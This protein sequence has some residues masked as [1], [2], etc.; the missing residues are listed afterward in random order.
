MP[1]LARIEA[2]E[3]AA[4]LTVSNYTIVLDLP[5]TGAEFQS[6]STIRFS[7]AEP[8]ATTFV[9]LHAVALEAAV[10]NGG[11]VDPAGF[12]DGRLAL[13]GLH[14]DNELRL[15]ARMAYSC[16]GE[17]LHRHVDPTDGRTYLYAMSFLDAAPRWFGC[18][19]QPDLKANFDIE[20]RCPA[21]WTVWGNAPSARLAEGHWRLATT[22]PLSTYFVTLVAG[23]YHSVLAE[24]DGIRLGLHARACLA[25][26]LEA[27]AEEILA[28][29]RAAFDRYHELFGIR[30]P[31]GEYHQAF[32][33]DFNAGAMENPGCVTLREQ[34]IFRSAVTS[35]ERSLR[36][37]VIA[38]EMA[39]MW[40]G[41]LVTM[42]WW[43]DLWLNESFAEYLAYRVCAELAGRTGA[44]ELT[45]LTGLAWAEFGISRKDFGYV[46]DQSPATHPVAGNGAADAATALAAFDGIS[47]A[48]G[49]SALR[50][51][52]VHLGD[53]VFFTGLR[54][55]F[56]KH[57]YANAEF[58]DLI[59]A[60]TEAGGEGLTDWAE[61]WLRTSGLDCLRA[62]ASD[63]ELTLRRIA[64]DGSH[65]PHTIRLAGFDAAGRQ[66]LDQ[67]ARLLADELRLPAP[68]SVRLVVADSLDQTW[69]K[70]RFAADPDGD[71]AAWSAV[72]E[73]LP[74]IEQ[75][76]TR[77]VI[78][79]AVRDGVRDASLDPSQALE[80]VLAAY[81]HERIDMVRTEIL[82]FA[83]REL[84][85]IYALP[86]QRADR[87]A[88]IRLAA[89][90]SL[91]EAEPGTDRQLGAAR[92]LITNCDDPRQL[93]AWRHGTAVPAG[94]LIDPELRWA[95][96]CRL[97]GLGELSD[98]E[99][100]RELA[101]DESSA[102]VVYA[103]L[104]RA[105]RP[106]PR[107]KEQAWALL[108][109]PSTLS[110]YQ[111][112]ATAEG[113]F[114]PMQDELTAAY[115]PRFFEQLPAT[116]A[117][118]QG[119]ALGQVIQRC[120]PVAAASVEVLELAEASLT[121]TDLDPTVRRAMSDRT[122]VLRRSVASLRR[123]SKLAEGPEQAVVGAS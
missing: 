68:D 92:L 93:Q 49:A 31:F 111:L 118:R 22:K 13:T 114:H 96:N 39:H 87:R 2:A 91:A 38:H 102:G 86:A 90:L 107:A 11:P 16:D 70:V 28:V 57:S 50:Q 37:A 55:H 52:A 115:L 53:E 89:E 78:Y 123:Y 20:V 36:S 32:V 65:R 33:P 109:E 10:L 103:A 29:T 110:A 108:T 34:L 113:F 24:H 44:A 83:S 71:P 75:D 5:A 17:G 15:V 67:P 116:A 30:Y 81:R 25:P 99:I 46:A 94:L 121:S 74:R 119:W 12:V 105:L 62:G 8:G 9:D 72:A 3:R 84:A 73:L 66:V 48:K 45:G 47:Y 19:D 100:E 106:D 40:F 35:S 112:Y 97:A 64:P 69:A 42:R 58:A 41:D 21:D 56:A 60:W 79:N 95:L 88:R 27:D 120:F 1:S 61:Q 77:V 23:P 98:A 101:E 59:G 54:E 122:D 76:L 6:E 104:A 43:D 82:S 7:C 26:H 51:L 117:H 85:S 18:F 63:G 14:A 4:L 80:I